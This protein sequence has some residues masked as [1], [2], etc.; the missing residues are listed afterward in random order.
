MSLLSTIQNF[1]ERTNIP[2]P[3]T[4]IGTTDPQVK[5]ARA[6]LEEIGNDLAL[7]G[8]WTA[9]D[10]ET[11]H[12]TL[13]QEDQ[14]A[15]ATI[16][17]TGY[18]NI[19]NL[20]IWDRTAR[21]PVLG[22]VDA[23]TWQALKAIVVTGPR[24]QFRIRGG[25]LLVNPSPPAGSTWAFE[26]QS[27]DWILDAAGATYK[28]YFTLDTDTMLLPETLLMMGL[29]A[30]WKKEKGME[31]AEDFRMYEAQ[32]KQ[33]LGQDGGKPILYMDGGTAR[34]ALPGIFVP[35]GSWQIP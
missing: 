28:K 14:G 22:P 6:L 21:L 2:A 12:T 8:D 20:T 9:L 23:P 27:A 19:K 31:Y 3:A 32:L 29:R 15:I 30:W 34:N 26:Y 1:C 11:T 24:Y 4:V 17:P 7:R 18:R 13:A 16:A 5:Q 25:R 35:S 33:Q 10:F